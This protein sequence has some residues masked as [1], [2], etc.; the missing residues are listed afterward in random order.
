V[1]PP[2]TRCGVSPPAANLSQT[3]NAF[4]LAFSWTRCLRRVCVRVCACVCV[5]V[6][7][8]ACT[9]ALHVMQCVQ[10]CTPR[11]VRA[12]QTILLRRVLGLVQILLKGRGDHAHPQ[13]KYVVENLFAPRRPGRQHQV[14]VPQCRHLSRHRQLRRM[15]TRPHLPLMHANSAGAAGLTLSMI[16]VGRQPR[17][18]AA[19]RP[20]QANLASG[21]PGAVPSG[22]KPSA[23]GAQQAAATALSSR[24][25][26]ASRPRP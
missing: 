11:R 19:Q 25:P 23:L 9:R 13:P 22:A 14:G 7:V 17:R 12:R 20:R 15:C 3:S 24:R 5:C 16:M 2:M 4:N 10:A 6:R 18:A 8:H 26:R 21:S 1:S